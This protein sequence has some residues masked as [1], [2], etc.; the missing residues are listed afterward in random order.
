MQNKVFCLLLNL[1]MAFHMIS[2]AQH[3]D[4]SKIYSIKTGPGKV[5]KTFS[6]MPE[7]NISWFIAFECGKKGNGKHE[8]QKMLGYPEYGL[9]VLYGD[10]NND[11]LG[12]TFAMQPFIRIPLMKNP[13]KWRI[14]LTA[15]M[16]FAYF[17][18]S[19]HF[20]DNPENGLIGCELNNYTKGE[21]EVSYVIGKQWRIFAGAGA[22]HFS[23]GHVKLPN[24]G[25]NVPEAKFG[26]TWYQN[27]PENIETKTY[28]TIDTTWSWYIRYGNGFHA[29]GSTMKPFGGPVYTVY[30]LSVGT[31]KNL[32]ALYAVSFGTTVGYY[33]SFN[34]FLLSEILLEKN[35]AFF[36]STYASVYFGQEVMMGKFAVYGECAVDIAKPFIREYGDIFDKQKG[37]TRFIKQ[38]NSNR[39]GFRYYLKEINQKHNWNVNFGLFIKSNFA[40]ADFVECAVQV[41]L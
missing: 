31:R 22:F 5:L 38:I 19:Y 4:K 20:F 37:I 35:E 11:F 30:S 2:H 27:Y 1:M 21:L 6:G 8:W 17:D 39:L 34:N 33:R 15:G 41:K 24:I 40:Q 18:N 13:K 23:N 28:K 16:G 14:Y 32:S 3:S 25:A 36:K 12:N 26:V 29:Y 10:L 9:E 7:T